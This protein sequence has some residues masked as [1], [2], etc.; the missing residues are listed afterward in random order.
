MFIMK[1]WCR[2][3][4]VKSCGSLPGLANVSCYWCQAN[5]KRNHRSLLLLVPDQI[6]VGAKPG[7]DARGLLSLAHD[8]RKYQLSCYNSLFLPWSPCVDGAAWTTEQEK[9]SKI[10]RELKGFES[11]VESHWTLLVLPGIHLSHLKITY[12]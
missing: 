2:S 9:H 11:V 12:I 8:M 6:S 1:L 7:I 5:L 4:L 10:N 3:H